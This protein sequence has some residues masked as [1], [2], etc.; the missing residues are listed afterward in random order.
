MYLLV[1]LRLSI[2]PDA[3]DVRLVKGFFEGGESLNLHLHSHAVTLGNGLEIVVKNVQSFQQ[4]YRFD[5]AAMDAMVYLF[6]ARDLQLF[7]AHTQVNEKLRGY[8]KREQSQYVSS[9][10][11]RVLF[12]QTLSL[13]SILHHPTVLEIINSKSFIKFYRTVIPFFWIDEWIL[14]IID[15]ITYSVHFLHPLY[16]NDIT[17]PSTSDER[18]TLNVFLKG[19]IEAILQT[20][21]GE[22]YTS[23]KWKFHLSLEEPG[24]VTVIDGTQTFVYNNEDSGL[25]VLFAMECDYFDSPIFAPDQT[26]WSNFRTRMAYCLLNRQLFF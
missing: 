16:S 10:V 23:G 13:E 26:H 12:D 20:S 22:E 1:D 6:N 3:N 15:T 2:V 21:T 17:N 7:E 19:H 25:Y 14:I 8:T 9:D 4:G 11:S 24:R 5:V 18:Y